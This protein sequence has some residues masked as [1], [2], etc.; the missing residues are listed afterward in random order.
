VIRASLAV[1]IREGAALLVRRSHRPD[2]GLWGFPGGKREPG[3]TALDCAIRELFEETGLQ[4]TAGTPLGT[5][6]LSRAGLLYELDAWLCIDA[7]GD[8]QAADDAEEARWF[9]VQGVVAGKLLMSRDVDR[10]TLRAVHR[11]TMAG[12]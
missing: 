1:V 2:A 6:T 12:R 11:L 8:A 4:A 9:D 5:L 3:E 7:K 10:L